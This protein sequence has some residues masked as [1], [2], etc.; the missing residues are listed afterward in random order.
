M[1]KNHAHI[2]IEDLHVAGMLKN[3]HLA[4]A[5][6]DSGFGEIRWQLTCKAAKFGT[7]LVVID[8]F[9]PG[10]KTCSVCGYILEKLDLKVRVW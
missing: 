10:F 2:G 5:I 4:Q 3:H 7:R 1:C 6:A 9:Y 8:R